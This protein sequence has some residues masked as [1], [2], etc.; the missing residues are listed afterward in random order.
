MPRINKT[1]LMATSSGGIAV[2]ASRIIMVMGAVSGKKL[3]TLA[4]VALGCIMMKLPNMKG[5][6]EMKEKMPE[7]CCP[8]RAVDPN[9]PA[10][11]IMVA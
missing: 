11:A 2:T 5:N 1:R 10:L 6:A 7:I 8:S 3:R 4:S 9:A